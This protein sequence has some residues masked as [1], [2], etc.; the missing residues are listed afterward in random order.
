[1]FTL[2]GFWS[3]PVPFQ[4][5]DKKYVLVFIWRKKVINFWDDMKI[6]ISPPGTWA[7]SKTLEESD[8]MLWIIC[9]ISPND[10][11]DIKGGWRNDQEA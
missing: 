6:L 1:M 7:V 3:G 4:Y 2:C 8:T 10:G 9:V 5:T 11:Q